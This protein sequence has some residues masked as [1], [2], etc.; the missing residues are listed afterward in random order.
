[1]KSQ[2]FVPKFFGSEVQNPDLFRHLK[3]YGVII[4][5]SAVA[6]AWARMA[7]GSLPNSRKRAQARR[8][9][10]PVALGMELSLLAWLELMMPPDPEVFATLVAAKSARGLPRAQDTLA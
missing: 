8:A 7:P 2:E 5:C 9:I 3:T 6:P 4:T 10:P 1:V